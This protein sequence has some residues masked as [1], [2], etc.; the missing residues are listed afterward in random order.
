MNECSGEEVLREFLYYCGL[1][2]KMDEIISHSIA[3]P[4]VM[5]YITSQFM[6]RKISDRP[7]II[8][9]SVSNL[10]FIGQFVELEG[11]VVFTVETSARTAMTAVYK[12]Y[13]LDKPIVSLFKGQYD[14]RML[15][16]ALKTMLGKDKIEVSDLPKINPLKLHETLNQL[17]EGINAI[18]EVPKYY[19][20]REE[21][22]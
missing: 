15:N 22:K 10:A 16:I 5:P 13:H 8:P 9:E 6:P 17:V 4:T 21:N 3:I 12:M 7:E 1:E 18:P 19:S 11:D 14:I 2:D 20:E